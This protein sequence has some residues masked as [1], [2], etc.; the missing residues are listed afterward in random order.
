M[1]K[2]IQINGMMCNHCT[3]HVEKAL[4]AL[5][6]VLSAKADLEGK[7]A[8]VELSQPV[9]DHRISRRFIFAEN[10]PRVIAPGLFF[11]YTKMESEEKR[12]FHDDPAG[13]NPQK[14]LPLSAS[15]G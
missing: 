4:S 5:D 14:A 7:C 13:P 12:F 9:A 8:T 2:T 15:A 1:K 3:A 11:C 10:R 6:G